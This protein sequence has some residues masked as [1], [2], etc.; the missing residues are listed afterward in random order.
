MGLLYGVRGEPSLRFHRPA[1]PALYISFG[2]VTLLAALPT[3]LSL[4]SG[5]FPAARIA[6]RAG[7]NAAA[8]AQTFGNQPANATLAIGA[9]AMHRAKGELLAIC[10]GTTGA[11]PGACPSCS[12]LGFTIQR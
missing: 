11:K 10:S 1:R 12:S 5:V 7:Q 4:L 2:L 9:N 3:A 6:G 8:T